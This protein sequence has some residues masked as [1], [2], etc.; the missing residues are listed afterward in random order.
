MP[1][2]S[3]RFISVYAW[4]YSYAWQPRKVAPRITVIHIQA[5]ALARWFASSA[6][7]AIVSVTPELRSSAVL[8]VGIGHGPIVSNGGIVFAGEAVTPGCVLGQMAWKS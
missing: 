4:W 6:W 5:M 2:D 3:F 8:I 7:W 1:D